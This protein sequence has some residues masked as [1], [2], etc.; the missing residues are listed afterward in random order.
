MYLPPNSGGNATLLETLRVMLVHQT[1]ARDGAPRGLE[2]AFATPRP[3]LADGKGI[4][5][6][7]TPTSF[8]PVSYS[9]RR[10]G[11][12]MHVTVEPPPSTPHTLRLRLRL[13]DGDRLAAVEI[14]GRAVPYDSATGTIE[15]SG[16]ARL[17]VLDALV[18]GRNAFGVRSATGAR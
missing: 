6:E 11:E 9:I 16:R 17:V 14:A 1:R 7:N 4:V 3:W 15:L 12:T 13:P 5:V 18:G 10:D 2:L 8:G